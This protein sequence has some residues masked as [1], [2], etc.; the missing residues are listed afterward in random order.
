MAKMVTLKRLRYPRGGTDGK[1][2]APGDEFETLSDR[3]TK[4][5]S[6]LR[7]AKVA[8][9]TVPLP[10]KRGPGRPSKS[11]YQTADVKAEEPEPQVEPPY[12]R[13]YGRRDM[14]AED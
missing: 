4:A 2:Y 10:V 8:E 9:P 7:L 5:L 6:L 14:T 1:D 11:S 13:R 12:V 3:D